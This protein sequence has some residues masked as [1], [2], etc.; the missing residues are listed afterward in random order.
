MARSCD[1]SFES[2]MSVAEV[3]LIFASR[4]VGRRYLIQLHAAARSYSVSNLRTLF[5][6]ETR[7]RQQKGIDHERKPI[8]AKR[9]SIERGV[10]FVSDAR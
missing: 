3:V 9:E 10:P 5:G 7:V 1:S 8:G 6:G 2:A 4:K